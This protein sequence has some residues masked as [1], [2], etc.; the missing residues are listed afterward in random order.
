M[1]SVEARF[2][3]A[4]A[5]YKRLK[6]KHLPKLNSVINKDKLQPIVLKTYDEY[7]QMP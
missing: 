6:D 7:L 4:K 3:T 5:D 1:E 2:T